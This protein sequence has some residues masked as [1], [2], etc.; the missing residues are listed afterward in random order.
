MEIRA[1][2][3]FLA[4]SR[5]ENMTHAADELHIS[6]PSL[7]KLIK[8]LEQELGTKLF[9]RRS[10]GLTLTESGRLL[11][12][13]AQ[14]L[15]D[16][17][18]RIEDEFAD[19]GALAGGT[20][21][22]GLAESTHID[23]IAR[24]IKELQAEST[25]LR[26]HVDS[27]VSAQILGR[28]DDGA[29]DFAVLAHEPDKNKYESWAFPQSD[30]W[31]VIMR[32]D[33]PLIAHERIRARD[34][35]G[36][37]LFCSAQSWKLDIPRWAGSLMGELHLEASFGLPY[38]GAVFVREGLGVLLSFSG[39]VDVSEHSGLAFRPLEPRLETRLHL[40]W[41]HNRPLSPIAER[42]RELC[43]GVADRSDLRDDVA[44]STRLS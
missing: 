2:R 12:D 42:F 35:V 32:N 14:D 25:G 16:M 37:P 13:R 8:S 5:E 15:I 19:L 27:G 21:Y 4:I 18:D 44:Q 31:G 6:Q 9:V 20:L 23:V 3:A 40:A 34:L 38:N 10:F 1:L 36:Y 43:C 24:A 11:R 28:L 33:S 7:S 29:I 22:F 30:T 26:Y 17:A 39:L 41:R